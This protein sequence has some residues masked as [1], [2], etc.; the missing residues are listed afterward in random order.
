MSVTLTGEE[1]DIMQKLYH[2]AMKLEMDFFLAQPV[3]QR[4]VLPLSKDHN[5]VTIFSDFDLTCTVVDS[6]TILAE[7]AMA[8]SPKSGQ[9]QPENQNQIT[10]MPLTDLRNT[11]EALSKQYTKEYEHT[12]E[13]ILVKHK[14]KTSF[15]VNM[16]NL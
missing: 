15:L 10:Q 14:G 7:I 2:Q 3:D 12:M 4:T 5:C 8:T 16:V 1:L 6:C 11:W 9:L 13:S